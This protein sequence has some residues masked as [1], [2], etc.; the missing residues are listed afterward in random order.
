MAEDKI[1][2]F[3]DLLKAL[4]SGTITKTEFSEKASY[5][6]NS[7]GKNANRYL[8]LKVNKY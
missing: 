1:S 6:S 5:I 3:S 4:E 7:N 8:R 2:S